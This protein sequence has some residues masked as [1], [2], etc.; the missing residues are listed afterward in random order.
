MPQG[1]KWAT[2]VTD[3]LLPAEFAIIAAEVRALKDHAPLAMKA[4]LEIDA[5]D[6]ASGCRMADLNEAGTGEHPSVPTWSSSRMTSLV[7]IG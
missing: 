7:V 5:H 4:A 6:E 2:W 3:D 1:P